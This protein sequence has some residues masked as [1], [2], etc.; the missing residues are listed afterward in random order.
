MDIRDLDQKDLSE[1]QLATLVHALH[2]GLR[3]TDQVS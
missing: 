3:R 2:E 1:V